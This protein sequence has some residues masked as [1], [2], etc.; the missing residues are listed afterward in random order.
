MGAFY[1]HLRETDTKCFRSSRGRINDLFDPLPKIGWNMTFY[2][3]QFV[4]NNYHLFDK[5][6][7]NMKIYSA[8]KTIFD[9]PVGRGEYFLRG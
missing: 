5:A 9:E 7:S 3:I 4:D 6:A 2:Q 8:K 1:F